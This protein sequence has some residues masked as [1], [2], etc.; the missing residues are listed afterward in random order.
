MTP[1]ERAELARKEEERLRKIETELADNEA[2]PKTADQFDRLVMA[3]PNS[4]MLWINYIAF[5]LQVHFNT[6]KKF[7][8]FNIYKTVRMN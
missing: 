2:T 8:T 6:N 5:H 4:S 7:H 1:A 3:N